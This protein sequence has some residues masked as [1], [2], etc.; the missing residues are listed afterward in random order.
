MT[1]TP[2]LLTPTAPAPA[3]GQPGGQADNT[4]PPSSPQQPLLISIV[5]PQ[6]HPIPENDAW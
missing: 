4:R 5:L 1:A 3:H 2:E 6:F